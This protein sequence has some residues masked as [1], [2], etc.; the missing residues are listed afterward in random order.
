MQPTETQV[1]AVQHYLERE[2]PGQVRGTWWNEEAMAQVFEVQG[3]IQQHIIVD[4]GFFQ[5]CSNCT[6]ALK[7][8]ELSE[9]IREALSPRC[10]VVRWHN[11]E[12]RVRSKPLA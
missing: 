8:S 12:V 11:H 2:F 9:Y 5:D 6:V 4:R 1:I 7:E 10:F 3:E